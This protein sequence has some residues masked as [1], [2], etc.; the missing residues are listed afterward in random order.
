MS[1]KTQSA[2]KLIKDLCRIRIS[3]QSRMIILMPDTLI[4]NLMQNRRHN[5]LNLLNKHAIDRNA[6]IEL[7][8]YGEQATSIRPALLAI[9]HCIRGLVSMTAINAHQC[10]Y[11]L[12]FWANRQ[13][14][15]SDQTFLLNRAENGHWLSPE[16]PLHQRSADMQP[17][18]EPSP[19]YLSDEALLDGERTPDQV[20][21]LISNEVLLTQTDFPATATLILGCGSPASIQ[22]LAIACLRLRHQ[23]GASLKIIIRETRQCLRYSDETFLLAAGVNL[24]VPVNLPFSRLM[25]QVE[26]I[27]YQ[28]LVRTLPSDPDALLS[29]NLQYASRGYLDN[30]QFSQYSHLAM[31]QAAPAQLGF[32]LVRLNLLPGM[33]AEEC[34]K[35][36]RIRRDGDVVTACHHALYVLFS[37]IR[38]TDVHTALNHIFDIPVRDLFQQIQIFQ[39][40]YD[41]EREL[42]TVITQAVPLENVSASDFEKEAFGESTQPESVRPSFFATQKP[43]QLRGGQ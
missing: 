36:C 13:G 39:T 20:V 25:S 5:L 4:V 17:D 12:A 1:G 40:Q 3:R 8:I 24:I 22:P 35:L 7:M 15:L 10:Q 19:I 18:S 32:A 42:Q 41:A 26:A 14:V 30:Q 38:M 31:Q 33:Q 28:V 9:N 16:S 34:L 37:A 29:L 21:R 27:Q 43:I 6:T 23:T 11:Q 2:L